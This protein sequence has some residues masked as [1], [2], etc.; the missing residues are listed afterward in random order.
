MAH[1]YRA[2]K[3]DLGFTPRP[4]WDSLDAALEAEHAKL[5][6]IQHAAGPGV[7]VMVDAGQGF[8]AQPWNAKTALQVAGHLDDLGL[9]FFEEPCSYFDLEGYAEVRAALDTPV[10]GGESLATRFE[11]E[12]FLDAECVDIAQPDAAW[13]GGIGEC[14]TIVRMASARHIPVSLHC[15]GLG[16]SVA[17]NLHVALANANVEFLEFPV[18]GRSL[19]D[20]L[21]IEPIVVQDGH[22]LPPT[23]PGLGVELRPATIE[24]FP[25][26]PDTSFQPLFQVY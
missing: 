18:R 15:Y 14:Q 26:V 23:A 2:L 5:E 4:V 19:G 3:I 8:A 24:R 10:A 13:C 11:W 6:A 7:R 16:V 25:Y 12:R 9:A 1:G 22:A 20:D 17:A 21:F